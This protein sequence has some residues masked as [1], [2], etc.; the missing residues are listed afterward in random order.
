MKYYS[1]HGIVRIKTNVE[2]PIPS[3]FRVRK[4]KIPD[5]EILR[6]E[7]NVSRP[8]EAQ[9]CRS[10]FYWKEGVTLFIDYNVP[11]L[12]VKLVIDD[13][14]GKTKI[15]FTKALKRFAR[16]E[17]P[18]KAI[19]L[20]KLIQE[21][22]ALLHG[23]CLNYKGQSILLIAPRDIGKTSTILS[24]FDGKDFKFMSDD[25]TIVSKNGKAYSYPERVNI[26]PYT[27]TGNLISPY[28]YKNPIKRKLS[29][30]H[31]LI[32][33]FWRLF[34]KEFSEE[35]EI[36]QKFISDN[37]RIEKVFFLSGGGDEIKKING[38]EA[39]KKI[40]S[41]TLDLINPTKAHLLNF[42]YYL[43]SFDVYGLLAKEEEI[44]EQAIKDAECFEV[45][46]NKVRR[47][48]EMIKKVLKN[49][50]V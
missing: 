13:L 1:L 2:I 10:F 26:Y 34:N 14:K 40:I 16:V 46:T 43:F 37:G 24:L 6:E 22:Y 8:R 27:L 42:Y 18:I 11:F 19:L 49:E 17:I 31:F 3:Y 12:N 32:L 47:Y 9:R 38:E 44:I 36:P 30:S 50:S 33:L 4:I 28:G 41:S 39:A 23:G 7:L 48:P 35:R 20:L 25:L 45:R 21:G 5:I 29:K 15:K